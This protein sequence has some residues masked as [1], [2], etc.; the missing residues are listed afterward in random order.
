MDFTLD[1]MLSI[2][3]RLDDRPGFD[4][5]RERFR[6][7]LNERAATV[8]AARHLVQQCREQ[9]GEQ[10]HRALQDTVCLAGRFLGFDTTFGRY[11]HDP[12]AVPN[13]GIWRSR[14]RLDV[15]LIVCTDQ[16]HDLDPD[17]VARAITDGED[18]TPRMALL[19]M[20]AFYA[21]SS[22]LE[23]RLSSGEHPRL[24]LIT[25]PGLLRLCGMAADGR[26]A[27]PDVLQLF[28][29]TTTLDARLDLLDRA[30]TGPRDVS[31]P[32]P[33]A[34]PEP[35]RQERRYWVNAMRLDPL[36]PTDR[37]VRSLIATRQV[38]G[39]KPPP[40]LESRVRAGD[41]IC[42][43]FDG[44]G[45]VAHADIAGILSDGSRMIRDSQQFTHVLR[46]TN[47]IV[48]DAP[49]AASDDLVR[50]LDLTFAG[51]G[52]AVT[53]PISPREYES[54]TGHALS[55]AG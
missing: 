31:A 52:E 26:I 15:H 45:I 19:V 40:G 43:F 53:T 55:R 35:E 25:L 5:P 33:V 10:S 12:G 50:R 9:A 34:V 36:T 17:T 54:I 14:R 51:D 37:I 41:A 23:H 2:I 39:I 27:H 42:V 32:S 22:R 29:P 38:L 21:G 49:I 48:Y 3:G 46:L 4:S 20:T 28:N 30:A 13:H 18:H 24:R 7:L 11:Q 6:R 47:V 16:T 8:D 1:Q 44:R